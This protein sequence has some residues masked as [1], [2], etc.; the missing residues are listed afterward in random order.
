MK[1]KI[2]G[3]FYYFFS[4]VS[5]DFNLDSVA[6]V[7]S[8]KGRFNPNNDFHKEIFKPLAYNLVEIYTNDD[9]LIFTGNILNTELGSSKDKELQSLSGYSSCGIIEDCNIPVDS[10]PLERLKVSLEEITRS[11]LKSFN[12]NYI[13]DSTAKTEMA[14]TYAKTVAEPTESVKSFISKLSAQRNILLSHNEKGELVFSKPTLDSLP[15]MYFNTSNCLTM[16]LSVNGQSMHSKISVIKQQSGESNLTPVDTVN[17]DLVL[18]KRSVTKVSSDGE[19]GE[20]KKAAN[21]ILAKELKNLAFKIY[22]DTVKDNL[23]CGDIVEVMNPEIYLFE[24]TKLVISK[25]SIREDEKSDTMTLDL[26][27]PESF[28]GE[29]P[30]NIFI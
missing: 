4:S 10:Y 11:V 26:V 23:F 9:K 13:I 3:R 5:I 12:V 30:K 8:F 1:I 27:L 25:I 6:S 28:T 15:K 19:V 16:S 7:F 14:L 2:N 22:L 29:S 17:N 18:L 24:K 20:T 21:N